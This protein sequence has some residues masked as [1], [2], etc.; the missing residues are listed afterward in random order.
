MTPAEITVVGDAELS[1][2]AI[3]AMATLLLAADEGMDDETSGKED[4][5]KAK[6]TSLN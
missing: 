4:E 2:A 3:S 5:K 1:D 6:A